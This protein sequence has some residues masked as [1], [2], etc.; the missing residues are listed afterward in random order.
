MVPVPVRRSW[1]RIVT[2]NALDTVRIRSKIDLDRGREIYEAR[3]N[4]PVPFNKKKSKPVKLVRKES[5]TL[6]PYNFL[7]KL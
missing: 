3:Y 4:V 1:I 7:V 6:Q 5:F 2:P